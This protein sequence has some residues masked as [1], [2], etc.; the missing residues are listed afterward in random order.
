MPTICGTT[1]Q[2]REGYPLNGWWSRGL[3]ELEDKN[4]DGIIDVWTLERQR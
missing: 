2:Q 1:Q 3:L 4:G